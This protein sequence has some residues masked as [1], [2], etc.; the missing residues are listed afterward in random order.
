MRRI[1]TIED[2]EITGQAIRAELLGHGLQV[3]WVRNGREGLVKAVGGGYDAITLD[4][5]LPEL[6]GLAIVT[7]LRTLGIMTPV[8]MISALSDVD[9]RIRGLRAGG[10]DYLTKPFA[11]DEMAARVEVLLRRQQ[12]ASASETV[13]RVADLELD[14]IE[15]EARRNGL[16]LSLLPTEYKLLEFMMRNANQVL[17]RMMIFEEVWG[18]HFDPGTNL[19][20]VHIGRLRRKI[21]QPGLEPLIKTVRGAGYV[22]AEPL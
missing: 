6:D 15:H 14:L 4:R 22:L 10:D 9:E 2:D 7:T 8:L 12:Q 1:L 19:I 5:M 13:L 16:L 18:Y 21:D 11:P 20:D 17:S 3:D